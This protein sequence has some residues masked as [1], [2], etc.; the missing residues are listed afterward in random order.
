[1]RVNAY[2]LTADPAW[3]EASILSYYDIVDKII[4]SFDESRLSWTGKPIA[5]DECL[6]R[7]RAIDRDNKMRYS[8]GHF[9]R[10]N[11]TPMHN[12]TYQRQCAL[13]EASQGADW[14]LQLDTDE[15]MASNEVFRRCLREADA[16]GRTAL[17]F[18]SIWLYSRIRGAWFL[19][20]G[21]RGWKRAAN[22]P[23]PLAVKAGTRL[24][25]ARRP[26]GTH[27]HVD[28]SREG[29]WARVPS[30]INVDE[31]IEARSAVYHLSWIRS[32]E[33]LLRKFSNWGHADDRDWH[34]EVVRWV[35]VTKHPLLSTVSSQFERGDNKRHLR[36]VQLP[37]QVMRCIQQSGI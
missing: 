31:V 9:A 3:I 11:Q 17:N 21:E 23:G 28:L 24:V 35:K 25:L 22:Y 30:G 29:S 33:W 12:D 13:D 20:H 2:I 16:R 14:V 8:P 26:E 4:V 34:P 10:S 36:L 5:V 7:L 32:E 18:P 1:M 15:V 27:Y 19:E 37:P 6:Q